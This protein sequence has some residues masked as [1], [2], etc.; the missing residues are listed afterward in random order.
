MSYLIRKSNIYYAILAIP[1]EVRHIIGRG[2]RSYQSTKCKSEAEAQRR[3][4]A[5]VVGWKAEIAKAQSKLP[6]VKDTFSEFLRNN[7]MTTDDEEV[8]GVIVDIAKEM[9]SKSSTPEE[10]TLLFK[11]ATGQ[12]T[13]TLLAP[14]VDDWKGSLRVVQ[15]T[16]DQQYRDMKRLADHFI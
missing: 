6:N 4:N 12:G 9:A 3:A 11:M 1:L 7:Y 13:A 14:L 10:A 2:V 5:L 16:I 8:Q 15:K